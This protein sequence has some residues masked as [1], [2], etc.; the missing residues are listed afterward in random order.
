MSGGVINTWTSAEE[1]KV[2]SCDE[3]QKK[4]QWW[5][6]ENRRKTPKSCFARVNFT[7]N[8]NF[9]KTKLGQMRR[10]QIKINQRR[11]DDCN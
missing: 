1:E 10:E 8:A 5:Y 11:Q 9:I 3:K 7:E 4:K 2:L 6:F